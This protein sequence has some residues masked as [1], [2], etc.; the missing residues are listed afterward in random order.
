MTSLRGGNGGTS[1]CEA[2][3]ERAGRYRPSAVA[4]S[5]WSRWRNLN[6]PGQH[7]QSMPMAR[8]PPD[9]ACTGVLRIDHAVVGRGR[10]VELKAVPIVIMSQ[11]QMQRL[12]CSQSLVAANGNTM[13]MATHL[14]I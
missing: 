7:R 13:G 4:I 8:G 11:I 5:E 6:C 2:L 3:D 10:G 12:S 1:S 14:T 9:I